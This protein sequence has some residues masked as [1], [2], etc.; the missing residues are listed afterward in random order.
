MGRALFSLAVSARAI[1]THDFDELLAAWV[2]VTIALNSLNRS[3]GLVD[4]YPFVLCSEVIE[5]LRFVHDVVSL[6][7]ASERRQSRCIARWLKQREKRAAPA[8]SVEAQP[9]SAPA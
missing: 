5:K 9:A 4:P 2:P 7:N 3:M 8:A 1:D 6:W